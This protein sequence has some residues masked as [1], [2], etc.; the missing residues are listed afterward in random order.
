MFGS[1]GWAISMYFVGI[2]LDRSTDFPGHPCGPHE[3]ERNYKTCFTYFA[4]LMII[5]LILSSRFS[6]EYETVPYGNQE[7]IQ[8]NPFDASKTIG[9]HPI[10]NTAPPINPPPGLRNNDK[11]FE[12]IDKMKS[13][14]FAQRTRQLPEWVKVL[15]SLANLR[16]ASFLFVVFFMGM[17]IGLVFAFLFW[18]LQDLGGTPTLFGVASVIN[19]VSEIIAYFYSLELIRE[20][21]H[22]RVLCL[23]LAGNAARFL[24]MA[25]IENPWWVLPFELVQGVTHATVW[26]ASCSYITQATDPSLRSSSQGVL[27]AL[28]RGFGQCFGTVL[29]GYFINVFGTRVTFACYGL[30]S[31][32]V[33]LLYIHIN[34]SRTK[35]GGKSWH[36]DTEGHDVVMDSGVGMA[37]HG[38]PAVPIHTSVRMTDPSLVTSTQASYYTDPTV[39]AQAEW[40]GYASDRTW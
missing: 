26:A 36:E 10:F 8:L 27:H 25:W 21:G 14:V 9:P 1:I 15:K 13:A 19:H 17:G 34:Y 12:F 20:I 38:V 35:E 11:K 39:Q 29:G 37:P 7:E 5:A 28:H 2:A 22:T 32:I 4:V 18:H 40:A 3:R 6:F 24:F 33:M 30:L 23:G 16:Y 31:A